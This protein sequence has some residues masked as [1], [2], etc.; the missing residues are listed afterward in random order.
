MVVKLI[1]L[2]LK[3]IMKNCHVNQIIIIPVERN[4]SMETYS[5]QNLV[6]GGYYNDSK[7][8]KLCSPC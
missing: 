1:R 8:N 4:V 3:R 5:E 2:P 6:R 7:P